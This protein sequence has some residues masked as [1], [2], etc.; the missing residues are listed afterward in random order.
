MTHPNP[1]RQ[2]AARAVRIA[3][4]VI[5]GLGAAIAGAR[6][7][8][9]QDLVAPRRRQGYYI[10]A[11]IGSGPGQSWDD[12]DSLGVAANTKFAL[13]FGELVTERLGLGLAIETGGRK[14]NQVTASV[15]GIAIEGSV[16][17]VQN[18]A[19]RG[20]AGFGVM[21]IKDEA[22]ADQSL[23]GTYGT[24]YGLGLSY[25]WFPRVN[26]KS[27]GLAI[28]PTL[29][30]RVLPEKSATNVAAFLGVELAWWSGLPRNQLILP[31]GEAYQ[32]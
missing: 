31:E 32:K 27:G 11:G 22:A 15:F 30:L 23:R 24:Q 3:L 5:I 8:A 21:Q 18:L 17:L 2:L 28:T 7:A 14:K 16:E 13:R 4:L 9:A 10:S 1:A 25:E 6:P 20:T 26:D 12:G 19:L 29:D